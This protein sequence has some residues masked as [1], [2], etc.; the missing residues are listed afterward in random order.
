MTPLVDGFPTGGG[1]LGRGFVRE[2][3]NGPFVV[4]K[5]FPPES[6][7]AGV[8]SMPPPPDL[9]LPGDELPAQVRTVQPGATIGEAM[10]S[11]RKT[12][13]GTR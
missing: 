2:S 10:A 4:M 9:A 7:A 1:R 11:T 6:T 12:P 8:P 13:G 5:D 3:E